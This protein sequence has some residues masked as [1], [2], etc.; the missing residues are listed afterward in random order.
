VINGVIKYEHKINKKRERKI[1]KEI[2]NERISVNDLDQ[3]TGGWSDIS[4]LLRYIYLRATD[5]GR[6]K[7][8]IVVPE[9]TPQKKPNVDVLASPYD[10]LG[11]DVEAHR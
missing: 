5:E 6:P 3:V 7:K 2:I 11:V 4:D 1:M 9:V 10:V 8:E